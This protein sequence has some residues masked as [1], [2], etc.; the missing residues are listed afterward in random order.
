MKSFGVDTEWDDRRRLIETFC[1]QHFDYCFAAGVGGDN[2][3]ERA[4]LEPI[5]RWWISA[6]NI[7]VRLHDDGSLGREPT[8]QS[9]QLRTSDAVWLVADI[10]QVR[11]MLA[12]RFNNRARIISEQL[13]VL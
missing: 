9:E 7:L 8:T 1:A 13:N 2:S 11:S 5:E 10:D 12:Q 3:S 6:L 4:S